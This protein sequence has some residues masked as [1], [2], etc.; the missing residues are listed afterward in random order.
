MKNNDYVLDMTA[1][2]GGVITSFQV[3]RA[4]FQRRV[5]SELVRDGKLYRVERGVYALPDTWEDEMYLLQNRFSKGIFSHGT[6]LW[7]H[8][9]SDRTPLAYTMTFQRGYNTGGVKNVGVTAKTTLPELYDLGVVEMQSHFGNPIRVYDK[10]RTLCDIVKGNSTGD[11]SIVNAA[12]KTYAASRDKNI[13]KL[14]TTAERLRVE[15]KIRRYM[16]VLL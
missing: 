13:N 15:P 14:M 3:S 8:G 7:M 9:L 4:G 10:E 6:A 16:E 5:L 1:Q 12:M 11:I 2:S